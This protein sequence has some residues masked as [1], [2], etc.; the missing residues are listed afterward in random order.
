MKITKKNGEWVIIIK[1]ISR[2]A[3]EKVTLPA[4]VGYLFTKNK[5]AISAALEA[6]EEERKK[7]ISKYSDGGENLTV[8]KNDDP[9]KFNEVINAF[10]EIADIE[11]E[12]EITP[13]SLDALEGRDIPMSVMLDLDCM[14]KE[15]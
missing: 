13:V 4:K 15:D 2:M 14:F 11:T 8:N 9:D 12:I 3:E 5:L 6:Y 10:N 7:I 1:A